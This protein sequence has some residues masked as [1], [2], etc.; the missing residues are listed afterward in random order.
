MSLIP[1]YWRHDFLWRQNLSLHKKKS[2]WQLLQL[3]GTL[4]R[5]QGMSLQGQPCGDSRRYSHQVYIEKQKQDQCK[6]AITFVQPPQGQQLKALKVHC[7]YH[8]EP[9]STRS[10]EVFPV[11]YYVCSTHILH[12]GPYTAFCT[13]GIARRILG[14][15]I[16]CHRE[17]GAPAGAPPRHFWIRT[18]F[19]YL[20]KREISNLIIRLDIRA[21]ISCMH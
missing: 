16:G 9:V 2:S 11:L 1:S 3:P 13:Y 5:H 12:S 21:A 10:V 17:Q 20:P 7:M 15:F 19:R 8:L 4:W 6:G 18:N 14:F